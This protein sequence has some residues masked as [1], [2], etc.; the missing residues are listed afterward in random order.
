MNVLIIPEDPTNDRYILLPIIEKLFSTL[1]TRPIKIS[2][3]ENPRM[4]GVSDALNRQN[5]ND[6]VSRYAMIDLFILC[7]DRDGNE[8]RRG[9][10]NELE[11][12]YSG[13]AHFLA[14]NA[15]EEIETWVLAGLVVPKDWV[16][17]KVRSD[18]SV[19]ENYF[20]P[21]ARQRKLANGPGGGRKTLGQEAA[22]NVQ[23][24][25]QKCPEDFGNLANR[26]EALLAAA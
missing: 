23:A 1:K 3:C 8:N 10:L 2:I 16:W 20:D 14:E 9:L 5:L 12:E 22:R 21:L 13:K 17:A 24:I 15:W 11:I 4:R 19:K 25:R 7:V 6:I 18:I 26:L